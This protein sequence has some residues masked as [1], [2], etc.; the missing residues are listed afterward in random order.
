MYAINTEASSKCPVISLKT[1]AAVFL[2]AKPGFSKTKRINNHIGCICLVFSAVR[3]QVC[4]QMVLKR[5][6][7][8]KPAHLSLQDN[9]ENVWGREGVK[10]I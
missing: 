5:S 9:K 6:Y 2:S 7:K 8:T 3:F 1:M 4:L 10:Y